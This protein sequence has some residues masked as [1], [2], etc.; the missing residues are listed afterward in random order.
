MWNASF[1]EAVE[2]EIRAIAVRPK[3]GAALR[4]DTRP[5]LGYVA[6][7]YYALQLELLLKLYRRNRVLVLDSASLFADTGAVCDRVF[8][9]L[10]LEDFDVEPS[11]VYNRGFYQETI[12]PRVA[13]RLREH[14]RPHDEMLE[15]VLG[16]RPGWMMPRAQAA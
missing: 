1:E 4:E 10:G 6:R 12:D 5:M 2:D 11:K 16:W 13:E 8:S 9:Y 15:E 3:W 14:Y 7:G